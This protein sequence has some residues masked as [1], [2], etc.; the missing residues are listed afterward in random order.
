[1]KLLP[2]ANGEEDQVVLRNAKQVLGPSGS[3]LATRPA[4][5]VPSGRQLLPISHRDLTYYL[6]LPVLQGLKVTLAC[7]SPGMRGWSSM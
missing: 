3:R 4:A 1:M 2:G 5:A 7:H 6:P